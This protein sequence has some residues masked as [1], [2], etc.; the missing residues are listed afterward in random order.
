MKYKEALKGIL[1]KIGVR[2]QRSLETSVKSERDILAARYE[3]FKALLHCNNSILGVM[4]DMEEKLSGEYLFDRQYIVHSLITITEHTRELIDKLNDITH[5]RY[6]A[7]YDRFNHI[8]MDIE[9][10]LNTKRDI[11]TEGYTLSMAEITKEKVNS[12]GGKNANLGEIK[13]LLNVPIPAGFAITAHAYKRF[14]EHNGMLEKI[15][16]RLATLS[17]SNMEELNRVSAQCQGDILA[18]EIPDDMAEAILASTAG[19]CNNDSFDLSIRSSAIEEDSDFSFA[20]QY[21]TFLNVK[22]QHVLQRYKEVLASLFSSRAIFYYKTK[23]FTENELA[24][25]VGILEMVDSKVSGV[26]FSDDPNEPGSNRIIINAIWGLGMCLVDGMVTPETYIVPKDDITRV[27]QTMPTEQV[28]MVVCTSGGSLK[29]VPLPDE[30]EE[31]PCLK[32][33]QIAELARYAKLLEN[34]FGTAQDIEWVIDSN[35]RLLILQSRPLVVTAKEE[36]KARPIRIEGHKVLLDKGI[37]ACKGVGHGRAYILRSED[38]LIHVPEGAVLIARNT[39]PK[40]VTVMNKVRAIVTDVGGTTG[41]M[42]SLAR[43]FQIPTILD[44]EVATMTIKHDSEITVDAING[45]IYEGYVTELITYLEQKHDPFKST[46]LFKTLSRV[47]KHIVMLNLVNPDAEDFT[48]EHCKTFHDITR[49]A[50]EKAML[51]MFSMTELPSLQDSFG[52]VRVVAGIPIDLYAI[53]LGGGISATTRAIAPEDITSEPFNAFFKGMLSM[54]WPQARPFDMKG[55]MGMVAH[56]ASM[57][58][59]EYDE[60]AKRSFAFVSAH[61]MNFSIRLGYHLSTVEAFAGDHLNDNYIK[62]HFK[63]GG[64]T[65]DRRLRRVR[66]ISEILRHLHF[67]S[68]RVREDVIDAAVLKYKKSSIEKRLTMLGKLTV[69][70]KQLDMVMYNDTITDS[71]IEDFV[72]DHIEP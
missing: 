70:T 31:T 27:I 68:V 65:T 1:Q 7:L 69:Y 17:V 37:I 18:G 42:A 48:A 5:N 15:H 26:I 55:F 20:G 60:I 50:H 35:D 64:S 24:M 11:P 67:D 32:N 39:S 52:A 19:L 63:G 25:A 13:N 4:A 23:G 53:D 38:D 36:Q 9:G 56:S 14:M 3:S 6:M 12:V 10:I 34:H 29:E 62:F 45:N 58:E 22:P 57:S 16:E 54:R 40:F 2:T 44:T 8:S 51:S 30:A 21:A 71:Y 33:S 59:A 41:H 47:L 49:F 66:L 46:H 72:Q 43:E 61:Y 28:T